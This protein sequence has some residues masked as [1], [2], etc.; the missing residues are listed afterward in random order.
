MHEREVFIAA[1]HFKNSAERS[2]YLDNACGRDGELRSEVESLL[3]EQEQLG[4]FLES[5]A[6]DIAAVGNESRRGE[7]PGAS[8]GR[9]SCSSK[10]ARARSALS[11]VLNSSS[12][13]AARLP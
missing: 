4:D 10:L 13:F 6:L 3:F 1:L 2:A 7:H 12:R 9:T 11:F 8:S 5:P